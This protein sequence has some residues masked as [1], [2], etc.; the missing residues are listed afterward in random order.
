M[1]CKVHFLI[2]ISLHFHNRERVLMLVYLQL[3]KTEKFRC[4]YNNINTTCWALKSVKSCLFPSRE[5]RPMMYEGS[6]RVLFT[7]REPRYSFNS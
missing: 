3:H 6:R 2:M 7:H 5:N 4:E 1:N